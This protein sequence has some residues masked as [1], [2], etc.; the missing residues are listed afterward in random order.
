MS[1]LPLVLVCSFAPAP[2]SRPGAGAYL[3][4]DFLPGRNDLMINSVYISSPALEA[5]LGSGDLI[6]A[7]NGKKLGTQA[8][9]A[10]LLRKI[11]PGSLVTVVVKRGGSHDLTVKVTLG[12]P[13]HA[14]LGASFGNDLRVS[15]MVDDSPAR[16]AGLQLNDVITAVDDRKMTTPVELVA[17]LKG[18]KPGD[19]VNLAVRRNTE[20]VKLRVTL[21]KRP[22][23]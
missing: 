19:V 21:G 6:V 13:I 7:I 8:D 15:D 23:Y 20:A 2:F 17:Y 3:G 5:G 11:K 1:L 22:G 18:K 4:A 9:L 12:R 16:R 14:H 10:A